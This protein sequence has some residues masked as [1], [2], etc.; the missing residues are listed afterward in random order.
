MSVESLELQVQALLERYEGY[1]LQ[2]IVHHEGIILV[3][4]NM[5]G[6]SMDVRRAGNALIVIVAQ[7]FSESDAI[8]WYLA[9]TVLSK[10]RVA[11]TSAAGMG[12]IN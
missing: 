10:R 5:S 12:R 1:T 2:D 7:E 3:R 4:E 6:Q 9:G 11:S 8:K